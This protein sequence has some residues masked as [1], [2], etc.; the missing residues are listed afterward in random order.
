[1]TPRFVLFEHICQ[2]ESVTIITER[3]T[4]QSKGFAFVD[5][6]DEDAEQAIVQ[7]N[8]TDVGGR[9]L[10]VNASHPREER[11]GRRRPGGH[12]A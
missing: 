12:H 4:D 1:M 10:T 5:I 3:G 11:G 2:V 9:S 6:D 8:G 7:L